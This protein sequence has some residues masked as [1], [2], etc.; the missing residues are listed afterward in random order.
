MKAHLTDDIEIKNLVL[1]GLKDN[2]GYCPCVYNSLGQN[3]YKCFCQ[4]FR[5]LTPLHE[6]CP[7]GL[8]I[9]DEF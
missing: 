6:L 5:E 8:Y 2:H 9:K 3:K 4:E 7:C 1:N